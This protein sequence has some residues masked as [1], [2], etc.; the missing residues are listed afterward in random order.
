MDMCYLTGEG[1]MFL[2]CPYSR[3]ES[4]CLISNSWPM[5]LAVVRASL[6]VASWVRADGDWRVPP[7]GCMGKSPTAEDKSWM[8]MREVPLG[9]TLSR[10]GW[11]SSVSATGRFVFIQNRKELSLRL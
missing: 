2:F 8:V 10:K 7:E 5:A 1:S 4:L 3:L 9:R 6:C 11:V